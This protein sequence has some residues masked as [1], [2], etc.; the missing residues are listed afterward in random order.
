MSTVGF[1]TEQSLTV[2][3]RAQRGAASL[4]VVLLLFFVI[5]LVSAYTSRNLV[6][7]QRTS[8]NQYR[9]TM[10][11][12]AAEAGLEWA[13]AMLNTGRIG[14]D[15]T[16]SSSAAGLTSF[17]QRYLAIEP[18]SGLIR[19]RRLSA[20]PLVPLR[21]TCVWNGTNWQ[22]NCPIDAVPVLTPPAGG[23]LQ[24]AFRIQFENISEPAGSPRNPQ[25]APARPGVV[26]IHVNGC[27]R[28]DEACLNDFT[29]NP[30]NSEG[31][32]QH[33]A[34]LVLKPALTTA[35]AGA[36]TVFG[37]VRASAAGGT[38]TNTDVV[39]GAITVHA[40]GGFS[41]PNTPPSGLTLVGAPGTP[42][43]RSSLDND[44]ALIP[45]GL[46]LADLLASPTIATARDRI[47][48]S[49]FGLAPATYREQPAARVLNCPNAGC[50]A[51]LADMVAANP[52]HVIWVAGD[53]VL[54]SAG[55]VGSPPDPGNPSVPG[56][57]TIVVEGHVRFLTPGVNIFGVVY[58]R[59]G[60]WT[61]S[62]SIT[63]AAIVE[64]PMD[65]TFLTPTFTY[66]QGI[67]NA[68]RRSSGSFVM[69]PGDWKD[70]RDS[71]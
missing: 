41:N 2:L 5:A 13:I 38:I 57:A 7:E 19:P 56:V 46:A 10:A 26:R 63:G 53:L 27:V 21:P 48:G 47:F 35:P 54:E 59:G 50:R 37:S 15:C 40:A 68:A 22:C 70:F 33:S 60:T 17:R 42:G 66:D 9:S 51:A 62:G 61:G 18:D 6:F 34:L 39:A 36:L 24:P 58:A 14:T 45:D 12:E 43:Y 25:L 3:G 11:F 69:L 32:A 55:D 28:M 8:V 29:E 71:R 31:R 64:G 65:L 44:S 49:I 1:E 16:E 20:N 52:N 23:G 4:V 30:L 67:I